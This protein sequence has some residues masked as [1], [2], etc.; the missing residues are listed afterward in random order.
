MTS[1]SKACFSSEGVGSFRVFLYN[2]LPQ[3]KGNLPLYFCFRIISDI[4]ALVSDGLRQCRSHEGIAPHLG[5]VFL[6]RIRRFVP[7]DSGNDENEG[8]GLFTLRVCVCIVGNR[9]IQCILTFEALTCNCLYVWQEQELC[10]LDNSA[11]I[12]NAL[13]D[14]PGDVQD[15]DELIEVTIILIFG[16]VFRLNS[17][18][19]DWSIIEVFF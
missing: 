1:V 3:R 15:V 16:P 2:R 19:V 18:K 11:Q 9:W 8:K 7:D 14:V 6:R 17:V 5:S 10:N 4:V 13:S 12:F